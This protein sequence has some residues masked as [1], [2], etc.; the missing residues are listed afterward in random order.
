MYVCRMD[1]AVCMGEGEGSWC[2]AANCC[3]CLT[4]IASYPANREGREKALRR[5]VYVYGENEARRPARISKLLA[6]VQST[7]AA[8]RHAAI[9]PCGQRATPQIADIVNSVLSPNQGMASLCQYVHITAGR[10][11]WLIRYLTFLRRKGIVLQPT[12][13][14]MSFPVRVSKYLCLLCNK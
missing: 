8:L 3:S 6:G 11:R 4:Y 2:G 1:E 9:D 7:V 12:K 10:L 13:P 14:N 5:W